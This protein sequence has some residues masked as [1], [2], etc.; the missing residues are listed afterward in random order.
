MLTNETEF[1]NYQ[2]SPT[3]E[4]YTINATNNNFVEA[5]K[6]IRQE[7]DGSINYPFSG[8]SDEQ[9]WNF[10]L[11]MREVQLRYSNILVDMP[12]D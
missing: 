12:D 4:M 5:S 11:N 6:L 2:G 10:I 9:I 7:V 8:M 1:E 3:V